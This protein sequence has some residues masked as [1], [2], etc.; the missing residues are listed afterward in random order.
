MAASKYAIQIISCTKE[1]MNME[2]FELFTTTEDKNKLKCAAAELNW[3]F[4]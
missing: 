2:I 3:H 4:I 1:K